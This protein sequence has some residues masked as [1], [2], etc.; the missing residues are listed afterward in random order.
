MSSGRE[1]HRAGDQTLT[2]TDTTVATMTTVAPGAYLIFAKT[3]L[4]GP[5]GLFDTD[6]CT[7]DAGGSSIDSGVLAAKQDHEGGISLQGT[8]VFASA[9]TILLKCR[10]TNNRTAR[11]SKLAAIKVDSLQSDA[12]TG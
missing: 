8:H 5:T 12:V 6:T 9:G 7:L 11:L 4:V 2:G 10:S 3:T 1:V